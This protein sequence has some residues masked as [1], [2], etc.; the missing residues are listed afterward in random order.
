MGNRP[1]NSRGETLSDPVTWNVY[2]RGYRTGAQTSL[3]IGPVWVEEVVSIQLNTQTSD[4]PVY[5]YSSP[6]FGRLLL[7]NYQITGQIGIA[8]TE[9]D[10]LLR[11]IETAN[12]TSIQ[13]EELRNLIEGRK[14]IFLDTVKYRLMTQDILKD[15]RLDLSENI[16]TEYAV[17]Y[18]E[19]IT[20]EIETN[21]LNRRGG[22]DPQNF[23]MTLI[24]GSMYNDNQTI[25]IFEGVK[26]IGTGKVIANDDQSAVEVY[27]F[28]GRKKPDRKHRVQIPRD[29]Y[30]F[31]KPNLMKLAGQITRKLVDGLL[32]PPAFEVFDT[33]ARTA[34]ML[35]T[36]KIAIAGLLPQNPRM[37]GKKASFGEIVYQVEYPSK[38]DKY[39]QPD[40]TLVDLTSDDKVQLVKSSDRTLVE[41]DAK[42]APPYIK[43]NSTISD[44]KGFDNRFGRII[45]PDR[46]HLAKHVN[47]VAPI[48]VLQTTQRMGGTIMMPRYQQREF[49]AGSYHPPSIVDLTTFDYDERDLPN[50]TAGTL[51]CSTMGFRSTTYT[52][53]NK[54]NTTLDEEASDNRLGEITLPLNTMGIISDIET[55]EW[56]E[57]GST[58]KLKIAVPRPV[59]FCNLDSGKG[60]KAKGELKVGKPGHYLS[61]T[62]S[63]GGLI[64]GD[65]DFDF[66]EF[67]GPFKDQHAEQVDDAADAG[68]PL[69]DIPPADFSVYEDSRFAISYAEH[70]AP[71]PVTDDPPD[72]DPHYFEVELSITMPDL[73]ATMNKCIYIT[74]FVFLDN[75]TVT[76]TEDPM[77]PGNYLP[78]H[79]EEELPSG[80][81]VSS[82]FSS[83][84]GKKAIE[85]LAYYLKS[86]DG[87][88][89]SCDVEIAFDTVVTDQSGYFDQNGTIKIQ[90]VYF[91]KTK[92]NLHGVRADDGTVVSR[93]DMSC[94]RKVHVFWFV[95]VMPM[96][97]LPPSIQDTESGVNI[98]HT[99][100]QTCGRTVEIYNITRCDAMMHNATLLVDLNAGVFTAIRN[101]L[102]TIFSRVFPSI[103]TPVTS[104]TFPLKAMWERFAGFL[105]GYSF[106]LDVP[107]I[108]DQLLRCTFTANMDSMTG[109]TMPAEADGTKWT[110]GKAFQI[111]EYGRD[112]TV[113]NVP[114][115][116]SAEVPSS[117]S[118]GITNDLYAEL[119]T[120][121]RGH[122]ENRIQEIGGQII[123][124]VA[125]RGI[126]KCDVEVLLPS[127]DVVA[128]GLTKEGHQELK[129]MT[130]YNESTADDSTTTGRIVLGGYEEAED[131]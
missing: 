84:V 95:S 37:Y 100:D 31:Y 17:N 123:E 130:A 14:S 73:S 126:M 4:I 48:K 21:S 68:T 120:M 51:W 83:L 20:R 119:S 25:E 65:S 44:E 71:E 109:R 66:C 35:S 46:E 2:D 12:D 34:E 1:V 106:R 19:R 49:A 33:E 29:T 59:D 63:K 98:A 88:D 11:I 75:D 27:Q 22:L 55:E 124:R 42:L 67:Q 30:M 114:E 89:S 45:S 8:Y 69:G 93:K 41:V 15:G 111:A 118:D 47:A 61:V 32:R 58:F 129:A 104:Y 40:D 131:E 125:G 50:I 92:K 112:A 85:R 80:T 24:T 86:R 39:K 64:F 94:P 62:F 122:I 6:Y 13:D 82:Y 90:G 3:F 105:S 52:Y 18:V 103:D 60:K 101:A 110:L 28:V 57:E 116:D 36:D 23:E 128:F 81:T 70:E 7:G 99:I 53:K 5:P 91:L 78:D 54:E 10:Y 38:Y 72:L 76:A 117:M 127:S 77:N 16:L 97:Q 74:P 121:V 43:K 115:S 79:D 108:V 96:L 87:V 102:V 113:F 56:D 107:K 9:P 26:I